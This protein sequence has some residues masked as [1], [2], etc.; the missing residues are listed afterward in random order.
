MIQPKVTEHINKQTKIS[1]LEEENQKTFRWIWYCNYL[2]WV[3]K[4]PFVYLKQIICILQLRGIA[5]RIVHFK[6]L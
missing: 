6:P 4:Q 2:T 5:I 1:E 3:L